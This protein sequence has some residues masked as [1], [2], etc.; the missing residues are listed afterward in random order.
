MVAIAIGSA[1][2]GADFVRQHFGTLVVAVAFAVGLG[3]VAWHLVAGLWRGAVLAVRR[4]RAMGQS[5]AAA[6]EFVI[7]VI[8][9]LLMLF[10]VM[11]L[12]LAS[13]ARVLVSYSAF[14]AARAAIVF[15]PAEPKGGGFVGIAAA[16][17]G[18][19]AVRRAGHHR[20]GQQHAHRLHHLAEGGAHSQRGLLRAH[21]GV[22]G[23]RRRRRRLGGELGAYMQ[24][25]ITHGLSP[26]DWLKSTVGDL[27]DYPQQVVDGLNDKLKEAINDVGKKGSTATKKDS[28]TGSRPTS[29]TR[30]RRPR[31]SPPSTRRSTTRS[32][33]A[34]APPAAGS[35]AASAACST[36]R[37]PSTKIRFRS[38]PRAPRRAR[39]AASAATSRATR[40]T[41]RSTSASAPAPT[42]RAARSC[43]RCASW[44]T[45]AWAR[46]SRS[47]DEKPATSRATFEW[48][49]PIK[50]RVT[51]L[52]YCQIPLANRFAGN[53]FYNLPEFDGVAMSHRSAR[54]GGHPR[55]PR[56][57]HDAAGRP[58]PRQPGQA[59]MKYV[60]PR[61]RKRCYAGS[62]SDEGGN[63]IVLYV[64]ASLLLVAMVWAIIGT[65]ARVMQ[66]ETIQSSA[67]AAAFSASGHQGQ[68]AQHHRL[69]QPADGA[70]AGAGH[71]AARDQVR[72][73]GPGRRSSRRARRRSSARPCAVR[74]SRPSTT[75]P[76]TSIRSSRPRPSAAS[77]SRWTGCHYTE[78]A[79]ARVTPVLAFVEAYHI[80][81]DDA[82]K[83]NFGAGSLETI[84][85]AAAD[86]RAAGQG[87]HL[88][89]SRRQRGPVHRR[90]LEAD[91]R[92]A[93]HVPARRKDD[94]RLVGGRDREAGRATGRHLMRRLDEHDH[95]READGLQPMRERRQGG[96]LAMDRQRRRHRER[97]DRRQ[98]QDARSEGRHLQHE[99][100]ADGPL[101]QEREAARL[102]L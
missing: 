83:K 76:S 25:R 51:Y 1:I 29:P 8:P 13:M 2:G 93:A 90:R 15:V 85:L 11:Q 41:A 54:P 92:Q 18:G 70:P 65:G 86:R 91:P 88:P 61:F 16:A 34:P 46:W 47:H 6:A 21:P 99:V 9:F 74:W 35:P 89:G 12:A 33:A 102:R 3:T 75:S 53:A 45:R 96:R 48:N 31:S 66:K 55:H 27:K 50:A 14:C 20:Q 67:D 79:V 40:S 42:A 37:C 5:G 22:A 59:V 36:D 10:G 38:G 57:L 68:G 44:S 28:T 94:L 71:V 80:G 77:R 73:H 17:A 26:L 60:S 49:E 30:P 32:R 52:F 4:P 69:L 100:D 72:A 101:R 87:R 39:A 19:D 84:A 7:V 95:H 78:R 24:N 43:A 82:Y 98:V 58:R 97:P 62:H 56:L 23:D 81:T 63:V 64:A